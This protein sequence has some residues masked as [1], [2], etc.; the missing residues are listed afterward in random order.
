MSYDLCAVRR[1]RV[2]HILSTDEFGPNRGRLLCNTYVEV[3]GDP[4]Q[5]PMCKHCEKEF[6]R[7]TEVVLSQAPKVPQAE[8]MTS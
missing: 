6:M 3:T 8:S 5:V 4:K 2:N 1:G 7:R